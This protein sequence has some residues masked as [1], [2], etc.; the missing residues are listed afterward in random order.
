MLLK[1]KL[2]HLPTELSEGGDA[3]PR[4]THVHKSK[5]ERVEELK[6][7]IH[8]SVEDYLRVYSLRSIGALG[9]NNHLSL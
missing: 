3:S 1:E 7:L 4:G 6:K 8:E 5:R 9:M 2:L